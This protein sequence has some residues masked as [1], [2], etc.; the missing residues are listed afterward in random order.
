MK[1]TTP[2]R[3]LVLAIIAGLPAL[4]CAIEPERPDQENS[5]SR[6]VFAAGRL[7][8]L[9]DAGHLSSIT[10]C[11]DTRTRETLPGKV[12][13]LC[14][15]DGRPT[16]ITGAED[17][18][19]WTLR[20][21]SDDSWPV[22]AV[23]RP[24]REGFGALDCSGSRLTVLT[25]NRLIDLAGN[26]QR[27]VKLSGKMTAGWITSTYR[28]SDQLFVGFSAGEFGG[29]L[30]RIDLRSGRI[31]GDWQPARALILRGSQSLRPRQWHHRGPLET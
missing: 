23:I 27:A 26:K 3:L 24:R 17:G 10:E 12:H 18:S 28:T 6:A 13:D 8:V 2:A 16:V 20:Q 14:V 7:W 30:N 29:G 11:Q 9:S 25:S 19:F 15:R 5:V 1:L 21:R 22:T 31:S 4:G